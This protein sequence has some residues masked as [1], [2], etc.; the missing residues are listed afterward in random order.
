MGTMTRRVL[1]AG[2]LSVGVPSSSESAT[3]DTVRRLS[4]QVYDVFSAKPLLGNQ[5][6]VFMDGRGLPDS[7]M[8]AIVREMNFSE[9]TFV[10]PDSSGAQPGE[11]HVR[12][13][14]KTQELPFAGHPTL[15]TAMA[16]WH[17]RQQDQIILRLG[18]GPVPVTFHAAAD[19]ELIGTMKQPDASFSGDFPAGE[20]APLIGLPL[21]E[22][23]DVIPCSSASTG[24]E[25]ILIMVKTL[26]AIRKARI[27]WDLLDQWNG[28][29]RRR[30]VYL[31]TRETEAGGEF[32]ARYPLRDGGEDPV[33][34]SA[35]G[36]AI[37]WLVRHG[38]V[39]SGKTVRIEQGIEVH[40]T[41]EMFV[42][43]QKDGD[44]ITNVFVGGAAVRTMEG[45]LFI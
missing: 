34:G 37:A 33:T 4:Y 41:G 27:N 15:G 42:S 22:I 2:A 26:A 38:L 11:T 23:D 25:R 12:I 3:A 43:A 8:L 7:Q 13:F 29:S 24:A 6:A 28:P 21:T 17:Q 36:T 19:G 9:T 45:V 39:P 10:L 31:M 14:T 40:R 30:N 35:G 20:V 16:L 32:H 5:L 44:A 1:C 18:V